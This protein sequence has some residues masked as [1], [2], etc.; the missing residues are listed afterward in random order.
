MDIEAYTNKL[1]E[2]YKSDIESDGEIHKG[3]DIDS[4]VIRDDDRLYIIKLWAVETMAS[5][6]QTEM[7]IR[8]SF[9]YIRKK[10]G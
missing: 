5:G 9:K 3:L 1:I 6:A 4:E 2:E 7:C 10:R 8:D